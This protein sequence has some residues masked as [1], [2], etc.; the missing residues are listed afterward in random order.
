MRLEDEIKQSKFKSNA[1]KAFVNLIFTGNWIGMKQKR[2]FRKYGIS[3]QQYNVLRIL[4]GQA[5]E[6]ITI[7]TIQER[8]L[9]RM[10]N[11][12]RLV[13]KLYLKGLVDRTEN[14]M[15]RRQVDIII[16]NDGTELL[17]KID[18][19]MKLF[20]SELMNLTEEE[21]QQLSNLLDKMR[22]TG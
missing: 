9:D 1:D 21:S 16:S 17:K 5:G 20:Q 7:L 10:S 22:S 18:K 12:S 14:K 8:M 13:D 4:R 2:Y 6:P 11:A 3:P 15:D 19:E